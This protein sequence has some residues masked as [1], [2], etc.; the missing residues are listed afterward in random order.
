[1]MDDTIAQIAAVAN[2]DFQLLAVANRMDMALFEDGYWTGAEIH[3]AY[4]PKPKGD[5]AV[6][7]TA[8]LEFELAEDLAKGIP[9]AHFKDMADGWRGLSRL[10]DAEYTA[11]LRKTLITCGLPLAGSNSWIK[12]VKLRTNHKLDD[13]NWFFTQMVL[14]PNGGKFMPAKLDDQ[15][16]EPI[17]AGL[18]KGAE[19]SM[20]SGPK[21]YNVPEEYV[22]PAGLRYDN[23]AEPLST[24][25]SVCG[26]SEQ[27]RNVLALQRCTGCHTTAETHTKFTHIANRVSG[28]NAVLSDFLVGYRKV[29]GTEPNLKPDLINLYIPNDKVVLKVDVNY[30][31]YV[32]GS[33]CTTLDDHPRKTTVWFHDIARRTLF[34]SAVLNG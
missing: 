22:A 25:K 11:E 26:A 30:K 18:W 1:D 19:T 15:I 2:Q 21:Q 5:G 14:A 34:L 9:R 8:I 6:S 33:D 16:I 12:R 28:K 13:S 23:M 4:G 24:P 3:F 32:G 27:T 20:Q 29:P 7:F 31:T 17:S 10:S